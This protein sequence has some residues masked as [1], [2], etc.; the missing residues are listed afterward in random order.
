[1][2]RLIFMAFSIAIFG[3]LPVREVEVEKKELKETS[4]IDSDLLA[5]DFC[6]EAIPLSELRIAERYQNTIRNY[7][8]PT[9]RK[10]MTRTQ[11][12]MRIIEPILKKYGVPADFKYIPLIESEMSD[13]VTS[14][15]GAGGYWQMMP[16]TAK[17]LGLVVNDTRDDRKHLVKSTHAAGKYLRELH[18]QL[19]SWTLVAAAYNAGPT[20][21]QNRMDS[22][23]KN[24][25]FKLRLN[26]ETARYI[27]KLLAVKEWFSNPERSREWVNGDVLSRIADFKTEQE[28]AGTQLAK[29]LAGS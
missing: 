1:M 19:G 23:N 27:Y 14:R 9:F 5:I 24:N 10:L 21:I 3:K 4:I 15:R 13:E 16:S 18:R 6:G 8:N 7:D 12:R 28:K 17:S 26:T 20:H 2:I 11:K 29:T 22:Q 25:Y